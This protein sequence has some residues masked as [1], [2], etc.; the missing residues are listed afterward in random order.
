[1]KMKP[2][3]CSCSACKRGKHG[4][5]KDMVKFDER[6]Y[7]HNAKIELKTKE[8]PVILPCPVGNYYD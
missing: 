7:R 1:M 8:D 2:K 4:G 3:S 5:G 6:A